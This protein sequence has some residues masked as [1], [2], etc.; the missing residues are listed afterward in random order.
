[1]TEARYRSET[2]PA[3]FRPGHGA[4]WRAMTHLPL[5]GLALMALAGPV[6]AMEPATD[7][8]PGPPLGRVF[9]SPSGEPVR[10]APG[11]ADPFDAWFARADANHDGHIDRAE[12]RADAVGFFK[13]L[14]ANGDGRIDGFEIAAYERQIAPEL[15]AAAEH[16][17]HQPGEPPERERRHRGA[18]DPGARGYI[19]L[20]NEP[21]PVSGADFDLDSKVTA[22]EW[23]RAADRRFDMLDPKGAGFLTRESLL[24]RFPAPK[25]QSKRPE[26]GGRD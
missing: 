1:M 3:D 16:G 7:H 15:I 8:P 24:A 2:P 6:L 21:E 14:D 26:R 4:A 25:K 9:I 19:S 10:P 20:I 18:D 22:A 17:I 11:Q 23:L 13:K 5:I 12:F